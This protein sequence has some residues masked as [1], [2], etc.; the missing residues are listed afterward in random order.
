MDGQSQGTLA[1]EIST[2]HLTAMELPDEMCDVDP[3]SDDMLMSQ[4]PT[5]YGNIL[6]LQPEE[7]DVDCEVIN[8]FK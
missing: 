3:E 6:D 7:W 2:H 8:Y 4:N 5:T 1:V